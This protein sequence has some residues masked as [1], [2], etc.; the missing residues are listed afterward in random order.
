QKSNI[1]RYE[2]TAIANIEVSDARNTNGGIDILIDLPHSP[3]GDAGDGEL[4]VSSEGKVDSGIITAGMKETG[5]GNI[6][7]KDKNSVI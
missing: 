2:L 7:V 3:R 4:N 1:L 6:T 5:T